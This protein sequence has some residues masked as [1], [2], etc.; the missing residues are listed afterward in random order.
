MLDWSTFKYTAKIDMLD[1][2][3][4]RTN[5]QYTLTATD[6]STADFAIKTIAT[7]LKKIS[8]AQI[9]KVSVTLVFEDLDTDPK[10]GDRETIAAV[11]GYFPDNQLVTIDIPGYNG[12]V[13]SG[14]VLDMTDPNL[15]AYLQVF[16]GDE[17][18]YLQGQLLTDFCGGFVL[19]RGRVI[20]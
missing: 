15:I 8:S 10:A 4:S 12:L 18:A 9:E 5:T 11:A 7:R 14:N 19:D 3:E 6:P 16:T 17:T 1:F 2:G 20:A 13:L